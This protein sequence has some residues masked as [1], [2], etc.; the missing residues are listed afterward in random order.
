MVLIAKVK[1]YFNDFKDL[2]IKIDCFIKLHSL[3][4]N[5]LTFY[6]LFFE[7]SNGKNTTVDF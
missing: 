6:F 2:D 5:Y 4:E 3:Q 7:I 1:K